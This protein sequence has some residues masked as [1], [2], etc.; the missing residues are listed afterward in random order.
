MHSK[1]TRNKVKRSF[2][3]DRLPLKA[4]AEKHKVSYGTAR[5]WKRKDKETGDDW[6]K[7]RQ[8]SRMAA[9]GLG[10]MTTQILEDFARLYQEVVEAIR[11][12][13]ADAM[14]KASALSRL[15]DAWNKTMRA[16]GMADPKIAE[17]TVVMRVLKML[18]E[19]IKE[20]H[21]EHLEAFAI[22]LKPFGDLVSKEFG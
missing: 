9:G 1:E 4:A 15:A 5:G 6:D 11:S 3:Y 8:A 13:E 21:P 2:V 16:A 12:S 17:L 19:F 14:E 20:N 22:I 18:S 7:A 10:D